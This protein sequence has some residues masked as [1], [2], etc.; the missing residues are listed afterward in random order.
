VVFQGA[1]IAQETR[2]AVVGSQHDIQPAVGV[3]I[4]EGTTASDQWPKKVR[5]DTR[6]GHG[7]EQALVVACVP[8]EL[9][10]LGMGLPCLYPGDLRFDV[11]I[12]GE[13]VEPA[14]VIVIE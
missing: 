1:V 8:K 11:A 6:F 12:A 4:K 13:Q 7:L 2:R 14:I 10:G 5:P 9:R 3:E